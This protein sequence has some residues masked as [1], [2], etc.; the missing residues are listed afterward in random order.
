MCDAMYDSVLLSVRRSVRDSHWSIDYRDC[1]GIQVFY[2]NPG[3]Y[4]NDSWS[5]WFEGTFVILKQDLHKQARIRSHLTLMH[6]YRYALQFTCCLSCSFN[7]EG[8][9]VFP[10]CLIFAVVWGT[11]SSACDSTGVGYRSC[12][13]SFHA[14]T[15][16][17]LGRLQGH[18][19]SFDT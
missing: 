2:E 3:F 10:F 8:L 14:T 18:L 15:M 13:H 7:K 11:R 9:Y 5:C 19:V 4:I 17:S 12:W 1:T 16:V 6:T